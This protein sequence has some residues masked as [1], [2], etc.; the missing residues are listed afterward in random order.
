MLAWE[1]G[2]G[3]TIEALRERLV[4]ENLDLRE[5]RAV[6][7]EGVMRNCVARLRWQV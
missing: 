7:V 6:G 2:K 4:N 1:N 5:R 3:A